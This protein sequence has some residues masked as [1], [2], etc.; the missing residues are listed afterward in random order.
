V[1]EE[2][3]SQAQAKA[4]RAT[5]RADKQAIKRAD[6]TLASMLG[7][8]QRKVRAGGKGGDVDERLSPPR[9]G[10]VPAASR[11]ALFPFENILPLSP[12]PPV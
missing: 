2:K 1:S 6:R 12:S 5:V 9:H 3:A 8:T 10:D 4:D 7:A 11:S